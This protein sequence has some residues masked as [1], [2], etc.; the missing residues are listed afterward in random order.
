[1]SSRRVMI[2]YC[3]GRM[4]AVQPVL[5]THI[6]P[7]FVSSYL[8]TCE[9]ESVL[10]SVPC[11]IK[12]PVGPVSTGTPC[13]YSHSSHNSHGQIKRDTFILNTFSLELQIHLDSVSV[14]GWTNTDSCSYSEDLVLK[15][16]C[17]N[18]FS[19]EYEMLLL[20]LTLISLFP[21]VFRFFCWL[22]C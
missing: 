3:G 20:L 14:G 5:T 9:S 12:V 11:L 21:L 6:L 16:G 4:L 18:I 7:L 17:G 19:N 15:K 22:V 2:L 13:L 10:F 8:E 1:M